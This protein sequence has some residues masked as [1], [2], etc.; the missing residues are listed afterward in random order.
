MILM[1]ETSLH[2]Y[3]IVPRGNYTSCDYYLD[4]R[5]FLDMVRPEAAM[6]FV[7]DGKD[8]YTLLSEFRIRTVAK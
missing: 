6:F 2:N 7:F 1:A 4:R 8:R 3:F 5:V